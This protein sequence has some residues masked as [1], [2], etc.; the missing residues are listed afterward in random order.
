M[1]K[2]SIPVEAGQIERDYVYEVMAENVA[3][4]TGDKSVPIYKS[5]LYWQA[6]MKTIRD[7][8]CS[9]HGIMLYKIGKIEIRRSRLARRKNGTVVGGNLM[10]KM[11]FNPNFKAR[12][13]DNTIEEI[14]D[15]GKRGMGSH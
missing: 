9:G 12:L 14:E 13:R 10:A 6:A 1:A 4:L 11:V 8:L 15:A 5:R 2:T 3:T 7:I